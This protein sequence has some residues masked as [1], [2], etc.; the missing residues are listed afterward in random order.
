[1]DFSSEKYIPSSLPEVCTGRGG[2]LDKIDEMCRERLLYIQAPAG[3]GKTVTANL[4]LQRSGARHVWISL[5]EYDNNPELFYRL[6]C[7]AV[8]HTQPDGGAEAFDTGGAFSSAPV[9]YA[10]LLTMQ[11]TSPGRPVYIVLDDL[12]SITQEDILESLPYFIRRLPAEYRFI[13]ISRTDMPPQVA[14]VF[15]DRA[16]FFGADSLVFTKTE[17]LELFRLAGHEITQE[18]ADIVLE[19]TG[20]WAIAV[21]TLAAN[22]Q[23][24]DFE[25][26]G[27]DI[28]HGYME[29]QIWEGLAQ[30]DKDMLM[31]VSVVSDF[32]TELFR[33]LT[34]KKEPRAAISGILRRN[35]FLSRIGDDLYRF[36]ALFLDFLRK[37]QEKSR[38]DK[39]KLYKTAA[40]YYSKKGDLYTARHYAILGGHIKFLSYQIYG[41]SQYTGFANNR[42]ISAYVG[43][44]GS[45]ISKIPLEAYQKYPYLNI[46]AVWYYYLTGYADKMQEALDRLYGSL[47]RI[48][49]RYP[50]FLELTIL[51]CT[52]DPRRKFMDMIRQYGKL[53]PVKIRHG[54][55]QGA[56]I[57][58]NMPFAHRCLRDYSEFS[59]YDGFEEKLERSVGTIFKKYFKTAMLLIQSGF[60][61]EKN[62]WKDAL[63]FCDKAEREIDETTSDEVLFATLAHRWTTLYAM[64]RDAEAL[65]LHDKI[66]KILVQK[67]ALY[68]APNFKA[69]KTDMALWSGNRAAAEEW[70]DEYFVHRED[71]LML[72]RMYQYLATIRAL[73]ALDRI[74]DAMDY[75]RRVK[76]LAVDFDRVIDVA[77]A[78]VLLSVCLYRSSRPDEAA[79]T[80]LGVIGA[81][82]P[83]GFLRPVSIEGAAVVPVLKKCL[84]Q[85]ERNEK[86]YGFS[87]RYVNEIYIAAQEQAGRRKGLPAPPEPLQKLSRQQKCM[88]EYLARGY[89][90]TDIANETGLSVRTVKTHLFLAYQ[91][92]GVSNAAD[93]VAKAREIGVI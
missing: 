40:E 43:G 93:A 41:E 25:R 23:L 66:E 69:L 56:S 49:L 35:L 68:L 30:A 82:H 52:L 80:M 42:S 46:S 72:Y 12:H 65:D 3:Y 47:K 39:R 18:E 74:A 16:G 45:Y 29:K 88:I 73:I 22:R 50:E 84:S 76:L 11:I 38:I 64:G 58:V 51:V 53:P 17:I 62:Q 2:V 54:G 24:P 32:S 19:H 14:D 83:Y 10:M 71:H 85:V 60:A 59:L 36:H 61:Y 86:D 79:E 77:E 81:L 4:W 26:E 63:P 91:K 8:T 57:T 90:N 44:V 15:G 1:M 7:S 34:G 67:D 75:C 13:M 28:L 9:E 55:Q 31:K 20:G 21:S 70:L 6:L 78:D 5:D 27:S 33:R 37:Q 92:L 48:A 87:A 89:K